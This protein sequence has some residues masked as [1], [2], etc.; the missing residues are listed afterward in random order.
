M[1]KER[2][3]HYKSF[4]LLFLLFAGP[5]SAYSESN[6]WL[7]LAPNQTS[8]RYQEDGFTPQQTVLFGGM[9]AYQY[10]KGHLFYA[11]GEGEMVG[12]NFYSG[13]REYGVSLE[14]VACWMGYGKSLIGEKA[15]VTYGGIGMTMTEKAYITQ[16]NNQNVLKYVEDGMYF[17]LAFGLKC[18][19][20]DFWAMDYSFSNTRKIR[21]RFMTDLRIRRWGTESDYMDFSLIGGACID[22]RKASNVFGG[23]KIGMK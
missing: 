18:N 14:D 17:S 22:E 4:F 19:I 15:L 7:S 6:M 13:G 9:T 2:L 1:N 16:E 21:H 10:Y 12:M 20:S 8:Y 23:I 11:A 3:T 5:S